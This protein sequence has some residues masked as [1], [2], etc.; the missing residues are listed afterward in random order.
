MSETFEKKVP[1]P[2]GSWCEV[3]HIVKKG[4]VCN[5]QFEAMCSRLPLYKEYSVRKN[6]G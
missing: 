6:C 4:N 2:L 1:R 5:L 3:D